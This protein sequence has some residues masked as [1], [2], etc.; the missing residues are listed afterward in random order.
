MLRRTDV[1]SGAISSRATPH[2]R[3][4]SAQT[5]ATLAGIEGRGRDAR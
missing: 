3:R 2:P 5:M 1:L 4:V